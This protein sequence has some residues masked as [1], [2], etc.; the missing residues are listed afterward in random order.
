MLRRCGLLPALVVSLVAG[1]VQAQQPARLSTL[2][3]AGASDLHGMNALVAAEAYTADVLR[4]LLFLPLVRHDAALRLQPALAANWS[5]IG[6]T[7]VIFRLR[8]DVRW[9]DGRPTTAR[10]VLFTFQRAKDPR[11]AYPNASDLEHWLDARLI[12]S[13]TIRFRIQP[14]ADPLELWATL[15][16]M[17]AHLLESTPPEQL[18]QA[19]F[20]R[21]PVGNGPYRFVSYRPNE[22][23][24]FAANPAFPAALGGRP[25]IDRIVWRVIP[26]NAA[27]VAE[28]L[29][30][31]VHMVLAARAEQA[32]ELDGKNGLRTVLKPS[33][34]YLF[35]D[36]NG[37]QPSLRD[38]RVRRAL[39]MAL[40]RQQMIDVLRGGY[41]QLAT[42]PI[43]PYHWAFDR[44]LQPLAY[45]TQAALQLL[46]QAG[47]RRRDSDGRMVDGT[48]TPLQL[49]LKVAA[50]SAF[51]RN[52]GEMIQADL[53]G[54][55]VGISLQPVDFATLVDDISS[56]ERR[57]DAALLAFET[58]LKVNLRDAFHSEAL[59]GPLQSA[60]Y[61]NPRIDHILE[62]LSAVTERASATPLWSELQQVLLHDQPWGVL[63]YPPEIVVTHERLDG[64]APDIR[65]L[66]VDVSSWRLADRLA[67]R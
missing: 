26:D 56:P 12:D 18:R 63:W 46:A 33:R 62:Q 64:F 54:I 39:M 24:V 41:A 42:G 29:T 22:R 34:R 38:A 53:A 50:G 4:N 30:G 58:E 48:G 28:L 35:I 52:L 49:E 36:W 5:T 23:W 60:S 32:R 20:N 3:I 59:H 27:Q 25:R 45:D 19:P 47:Y 7:V 31:Q 21:A 37:L 11:T 44:S 43:A 17:P 9:H 1:P 10:D 40:N 51:N 57:F 8:P 14:H 66:F 6:D 15:P 55:G 13:L 2:V 61:S 65:G 67:N 16:I